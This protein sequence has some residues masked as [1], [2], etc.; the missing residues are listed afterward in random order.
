MIDLR[1]PAATGFAIRDP[2]A[3]DDLRRLVGEGEA[4]GYGAVFL[5][6][7]DGRD[8]FVALAAIAGVTTSLALANGIAP[9]TSRPVWL[10]AM[11]AAAVQERSGGRHIVGLGTGRPGAGALDRLREQVDA[12]RRLFRGERVGDRSLSLEL[13]QPPPIWISALGPRAV[14]LAGEVADGVLLNWCTPERVGEA[15]SAALRAADRAGRERPPTVAVYVRGLLG[16]DRTPLGQMA[17]QYASYPAYARQFD[18]MGV[19]DEARAAAAG[20]PEGLVSAVCL[21]A[22]AA[23]ARSRLRAYRDAGAELP[24]VYPVVAGR[25][26]ADDAFVTL[27]ALAPEGG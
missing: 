15:R 19:G 16:R 1:Q 22:D 4:L 12:L 17:S 9:M 18:A 7:I 8:T 27:R 3:W 5:P 20:S 6:E 11:A 13:D 26:G 2:F 23:A 21:P 10:T 25:E 24:I 14:E